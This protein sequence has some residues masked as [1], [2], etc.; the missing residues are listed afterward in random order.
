MAVRTGCGLASGTQ[1]PHTSARSGDDYRQ[2]PRIDGGQVIFGG[3]GAGIRSTA[4]G[5]PSLEALPVRS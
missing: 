4:G 2:D 1:G 5:G 3:G